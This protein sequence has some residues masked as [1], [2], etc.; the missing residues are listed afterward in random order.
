MNSGETQAMGT[1]QA[2]NT[3]RDQTSTW[4]FSWSTATHSV[5]HAHAANTSQLRSLP[6][7][8]LFL[9]A[10]ATFLG[11]PT[12][13]SPLDA[14]SRLLEGPCSMELA[15]SQ[16]HQK[17]HSTGPC[18]SG[19]S[20]HGQAPR[21]NITAGTESPDLVL[22]CS[23]R[24]KHP[25]LRHF[26]DLIPCSGT[27]QPCCAGEKG[28]H[29]VPRHLVRAGQLHDTPVPRWSRE[30]G[31]MCHLASPALAEQ[32]HHRPRAT[33]RHS[34]QCPRSQDSTRPSNH[35]PVCPGL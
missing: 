16:L 1:G 2:G 31:T 33:S 23:C 18:G 14:M 13:S 21:H 24:H 7:P 30:P 34:L 29:H 27:W 20:A 3:Q 19:G 22:W 25:Q 32:T 11:A 8:V 35:F 4:M 9:K 26:C 5:P 12:L 17:L 28:S 10:E 15:L 6:L